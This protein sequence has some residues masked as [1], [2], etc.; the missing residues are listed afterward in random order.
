MAT[1]YAFIMLEAD[2]EV[3]KKRAERTKKSKLDLK[4][5]QTLLSLF[6]PT[7]IYWRR[8]IFFEK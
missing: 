1:V 6:I 3:K 7:S 5:E 2:R 4:H 8:W